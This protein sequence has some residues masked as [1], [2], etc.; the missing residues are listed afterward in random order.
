T[1]VCEKLKRIQPETLGAAS[2]ISGVTPAAIVA[3]LRYVKRGS[4]ELTG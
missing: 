2:R 3:I 1:E 4:A